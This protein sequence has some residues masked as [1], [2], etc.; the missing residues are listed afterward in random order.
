MAQPRKS[1]VNLILHAA[2][3]L[4]FSAVGSFAD[5]RVAVIVNA[6]NPSTSVTSDELKRIYRGELGRWEFASESKPAVKLA[7]YEN[8]LT[9]IEKFYKTATGLTPRKL[10]T[11]WFGMAFRGEIPELPPRLVSEKK[12]IAH[13]AKNPHSI[14][15]VDAS[16][17]ATVPP[18]IK[19]LKIDAKSPDDPEYLIR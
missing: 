14:G 4:S 1:P 2:L 16:L 19:I 11:R 12:M 8:S 18:N 6:E 17:L 13:V 10:R 5:V 3:L 9:Y 15:F 7:D